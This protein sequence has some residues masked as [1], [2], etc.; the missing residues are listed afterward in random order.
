MPT[1]LSKAGLDIDGR[2]GILDHFMDQLDL[3]VKFQGL[4]DP[5][6]SLVLKGHQPVGERDLEPDVALF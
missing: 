4:V 3:L 6:E 1:Y 2:V 5:T